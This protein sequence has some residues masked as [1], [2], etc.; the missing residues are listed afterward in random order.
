MLHDDTDLTDRDKQLLAVWVADP[1]RAWFG[2]DLMK[3]LGW[4]SGK[5]YP[6]LARLEARRWLVTEP[7]QLDA[8]ETRPAR[9]FYRLRPGVLDEARAVLEGTS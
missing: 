2:F 5:L 8:E 7:E 3:H 1:D 4:G 6:S 9:R